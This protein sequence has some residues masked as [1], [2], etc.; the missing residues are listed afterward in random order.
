MTLIA[1]VLLGVSVMLLTIALWP[2]EEAPQQYR[3]V[4]DERVPRTLH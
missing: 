3:F 1:A 4:E 2:G